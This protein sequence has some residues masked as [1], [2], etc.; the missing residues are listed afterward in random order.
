M[1]DPQNPCASPA[2]DTRCPRCGGAFHCGMHDAAPC[3]CAVPSLP[4]A[5]LAALRAR[6]SGCLCLACLTAVAAGSPLEA[7]VS[8]GPAA[9]AS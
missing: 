1:D 6:Y 5:T 4:A 3:P 9:A 8:A 7:V 2:H